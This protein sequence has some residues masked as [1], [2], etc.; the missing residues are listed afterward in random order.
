MKRIRFYPKH[1]ENLYVDVGNHNVDAVVVVDADRDPLVRFKSPVTYS[2]I[3][4]LF[5]NLLLIRPCSRKEAIAVLNIIQN[6]FVYVANNNLEV[7]VND[8]SELLIFIKSP[9]TILKTCYLF[10]RSLYQFE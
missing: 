6:A 10:G 1:H 4:N 2:K 8:E 9:V 7:V 5:K 3:C